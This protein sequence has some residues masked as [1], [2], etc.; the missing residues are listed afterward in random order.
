MSIL[1]VFFI[2]FGLVLLV[3]LIILLRFL[4]GYLT[5]EEYI[6]EA[7]DVFRL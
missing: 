5:I 2:A 3:Q 1:I 6:E 4:F 7:K